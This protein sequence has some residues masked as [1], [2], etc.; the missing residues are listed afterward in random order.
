MSGINRTGRPSSPL[1]PRAGNETPARSPAT[2]D[3]GGP[4]RGR[5]SHSV[6][7][8]LGRPFRRTSASTQAHEDGGAHQ[9]HD[10]GHAAGG[11][12]APRAAAPSLR[13]SNALPPAFAERIVRE[14]EA[15][16]AEARNR[17]AGGT[18]P[19]L[20]THRAAAPPGTAGG[21][22]AAQAEVIVAQFRHA[23]VDLADAREML[24]QLMHGDAVRLSAP[25]AAVL[26]SHFPQMLMVGIGQ[27][28]PL[29]VALHEALVGAAPPPPP[30][31]PRS[32]AVGQL[33]GR[34][35]PGSSSRP[36]A[37][38]HAVNPNA[39]APA[40][41]A[42]RTNARP[43]SAHVEQLARSGVDMTRL[44][45][46]IDN[47]VLYGQDLPAD[48]RQ[49]LR[50]AGVDTHIEDNVT[51]IDHP[52]ML[53]RRAMRRPQA[54][55]SRAS[56]QAA[57]LAARPLDAG[58]MRPAERPAALTM[59]GRGVGENNGQYA[60]RVLTQN[61][62]ASPRAVASA[63][64]RASGG[65]RT[66]TLEALN[67]HIATYEQICAAFDDLRPISKGQARHLGFNDAAIYNRDDDGPLSRDHAT[68]CLFGEELSLSNPNQRVMGL[69]QV[70]SNPARGYNA[71]VNK[72]LV[73]M[74]MRKLAE[75]LVIA[76]I[77][78]M[79]NMPLTADNIRDFAFKIA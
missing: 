33:Q 54:S 11:S 67:E 43:S 40:R 16:Q 49:A 50:R 63:V 66:E 4:S 25:V 18:R 68:N 19:R 76:P 38:P 60:W 15:P 8:F 12:A 58:R 21:T 41:Q 79:N 39:P 62:G 59:P 72:A 5:Q 37:P 55:A 35:T 36:L 14:Q 45:N 44:G 53:L 26:R 71:D 13:R 3:A 31:A 77:H 75:Y 7:G 24:S 20:S 28:D 69:A 42:H 22:P 74:D 64:V 73:F 29:G 2:P 51:L 65:S 27:H 32:P 30:A 52:L 9:P 70:A 1:S 10:P 48:L 56:A 47:A 61:P 57:P 23:G 6:F 78:P 34:A 46:A 17:P